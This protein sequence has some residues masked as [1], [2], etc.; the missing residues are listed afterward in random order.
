MAWNEPNNPNRDPWNSGRRGGGPPDLDEMLKRLRARFSGR[1]GGP[2]PTTGIALILA[3][4]LGLW[5]ASGFYVVDEKERAV[6]LRFGAYARTA[7]PGLGWRLP[8][9][10][11]RERKVNV[12]GVRSVSDK[13]DL[14]TRD[15]NLLTV[16]LTVQYRVASPENFLFQIAD[17]DKTLSETTKWAVRQ[18]VGRVTMDQ[19]L[20]EGSRAVAAQTQRLLQERLDTYKAGLSV[21]EMSLQSVRPPEAVQRE[22]DEANKAAEEQKRLRND[23]EAYAEDRLPKANGAAA[24]ELAEAASYRDRVIAT[25]EGESARFTALLAEYKKAPKVTRERLYLDAMRDILSNTSKVI[26]DVDKT[27][28]VIYLPLEQLLKGGQLPNGADSLPSMSASPPRAGSN[29]QESR[30][31]ERGAR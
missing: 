31:R 17:P 28:P 26:L 4:L 6:I 1:R 18:A 9:P 13:S 27:G 22:F 14:L 2:L 21:M 12:T 5:L 11:E 20:A 24:R 25:A 10:I 29:A 8:R 16:E 3:S 7:D 19:V 23:A 30:S 15:E